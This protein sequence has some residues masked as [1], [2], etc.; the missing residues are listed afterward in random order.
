MNEDIHDCLFFLGDSIAVS[1]LVPI[2]ARSRYDGMKTHRK[3]SATKGV[4]AVFRKLQT[5][6]RFLPKLDKPSLGRNISNF[7][8][9][10]ISDGQEGS[11]VPSIRG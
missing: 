2:S 7:Q 10:S 3:A 9:Q 4:K 5:A 1:Q 6:E 8:K 11:C